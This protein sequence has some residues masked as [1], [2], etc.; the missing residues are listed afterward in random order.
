M[1]TVSFSVEAEAAYS[2]A[3]EVFTLED[4]PHDWARTQ[5]NAGRVLQALGEREPGTACLEGAEAAYSA[6]GEVFTLED[7]CGGTRL[8]GVCGWISE[9]IRQVPR[10][11]L[12]VR[13][14]SL[15]P[16]R[17]H[18][19]WG[20]RARR[21]VGRRADARRHSLNAPGGGK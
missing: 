20:P 17:A 13:Q 11:A 15:Y 21:R 9:R 7:S 8:Q 6:A 1:V 14:G 16:A 3:G 4:E 18:G 19:G 12:E 5:C 2:A 10:E